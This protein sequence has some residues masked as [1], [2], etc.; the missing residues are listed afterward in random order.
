MVYVIRMLIRG[1][2]FSHALCLHVCDGASEFHVYSKKGW[3]SFNPDKGALIITAGDQ[4]QVNFDPVFAW[5]TKQQKLAKHWL[6]LFHK[7]HKSHDL[8]HL[9]E[10]V[11]EIHWWQPHHHD[12]KQA[13]FLQFILISSSLF[14][15]ICMYYTLTGIKWW[16]LQECDRKANLWRWE[17][18]L[19]IN[20]FPL[21][22]SKH[23]HQ[24]LLQNQQGEVYFSGSTSLGGFR[25]DSYIPIFRLH[26]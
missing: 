22:S 23:H 18:E 1:T 3:V 20:G 12:Q 11:H 16:E 2:D 26:L 21:F 4:I 15:C 5:P 19:Y 6:I 7:E 24:Q 17:R 25:F 13:L 9:L 8:G 14:P 10:H